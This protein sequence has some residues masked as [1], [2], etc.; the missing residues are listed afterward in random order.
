[1]KKNKSSNF[2]VS[3]LLLIIAF[4][5]IT[6][7][8]Q[9]NT[10]GISVSDDYSTLTCTSDISTYDSDSAFDYLV[11]DI[12]KYKAKVKND[13]CSISN[14][15]DSSD[16]D[17]SILFEYSIHYLEFIGIHRYDISQHFYRKIIADNPNDALSLYLK[18]KKIE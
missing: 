9:N 3:S 13:I 2:Y 18:R 12:Y 4:A 5:A 10:I 15:Y 7:F 14:S 11:N 8:V 16:R 1:M 6:L 17:R